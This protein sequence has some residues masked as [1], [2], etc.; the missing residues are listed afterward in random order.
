MVGRRIERDQSPESEEKKKRVGAAVTGKVVVVSGVS[1]DVEAGR[2]TGVSVNRSPH[3]LEFS[4][5]QIAGFSRLE[6]DGSFCWR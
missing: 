3:D 2:K 5:L 1:R 4:Q 6:R